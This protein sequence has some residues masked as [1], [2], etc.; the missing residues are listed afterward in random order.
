MS[1]S[2]DPKPAR[3]IPDSIM[4]RD[5]AHG[6]PATSAPAALVTTL[7][8][9]TAASGQSRRHGTCSPRRASPARSSNTTAASAANV[10]CTSM[11]WRAGTRSVFNPGS[12]ASSG[13]RPPYRP[14]ASTRLNAPKTSS[15]TTRRRRSRLR[16]RT[17]THAR[18]SVQNAPL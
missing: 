11:M 12:S 18:L 10:R 7:R 16:Q 3:P 1:T 17:A 5:V 14:S 13:Y 8:M 6:L 9:A 2:A 15:A 4:K